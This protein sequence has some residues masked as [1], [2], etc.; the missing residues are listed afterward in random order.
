MFKR[1]FALFVIL[2][3]AHALPNASDAA[4][5]SVKTSDFIKVEVIKD[6]APLHDQP[7]NKGK[8]VEKGYY[9]MDDYE[10]YVY[11]FLYVEPQP[12][13]SAGTSWYK[14][15]FY[16]AAQVKFRYNV[17]YLY[18]NTKDVRKVPF[19]HDSENDPEK[20]FLEWFEQ[21]RPPRFKVGDDFAKVKE[22]G[23]GDGK[24]RSA[25]T[26]VPIKLYREPGLTAH[27][28]MLPIGTLIIDILSWEVHVRADVNSWPNMYLFQETGRYIDMQDHF[29]YAIVN[30][31]NRKVIGW[32]NS[33]DHEFLTQWDSK[34]GGN[35]DKE[36]LTPPSDSDVDK[37]CEKVF[38]Y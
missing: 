8:I 20:I 38:I 16:D 35:K 15:L 28:S 17:P 33:D 34:N 7:S 19:S 14:V 26:I 2:L 37:N 27:S 25:K 18:V 24:F 13:K 10:D 1:F 32:I 31:N 21:G 4:S 22:L 11:A 30:A 29:W 36:F 5:N 6:N 9:Y 23:Y 3:F 12:I